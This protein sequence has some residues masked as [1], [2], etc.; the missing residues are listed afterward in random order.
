MRRKDNELARL[1]RVWRMSGPV[2]SRRELL[3]WSAVAAGAVAS[4]TGTLS[5]APGGTRPATSRFQDGEFETN[6][7]ITVPLDP[8]GQPVTLDPHRSVNWGPFWALFPIVW[9]GLVR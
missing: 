2:G 4:T 9:G 5:A 6:V 1:E 7:E 3:K 8:Y